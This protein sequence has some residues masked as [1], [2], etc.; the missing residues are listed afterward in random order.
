MPVNL[1]RRSVAYLRAAE[2]LNSYA[3]EEFELGDSISKAHAAEH[4]KMAFNL[5]KDA[6]STFLAI[7]EHKLDSTYTDAPEYMLKVNKDT[8]ELREQR[9]DLQTSY[10]QGVHARGCGDVHL[11]TVTYTLKP[12]AIAN[13]FKVSAGVHVSAGDLTFADTIKYV[14]ER[15]LDELAL[16]AAFEGNRFGDLIRFAE[17][18]GEP[19]LLINRVANR[20][21]VLNQSLSGTLQNKENWYIPLPKK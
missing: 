10:F 3:A 8:A 11:D 2:A 21:G 19:E 1:Y 14:E 13:Y 15:I 16:E 9:I 18:R 6:Y 12:T 4:V 20:G 7:N 5:L 17:R